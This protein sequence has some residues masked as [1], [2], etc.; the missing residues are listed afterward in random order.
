MTSLKTYTMIILNRYIMISYLPRV[1]RSFFFVFGVLR[2]RWLWP[3]TGWRGTTSPGG[4][5]VAG[6]SPPAWEGGSVPW[7]EAAGL[8]LAAAPA[9]SEDETKSKLNNRKEVH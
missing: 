5:V 7:G 1:P 9:T 6:S 3:P 4:P 8:P 2:T